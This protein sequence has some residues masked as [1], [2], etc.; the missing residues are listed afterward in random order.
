[1]RFIHW[2]W[3][4]LAFMVVAAC[5]VQQESGDD[6]V[7]TLQKEFGPPAPT[8]AVGEDEARWEFPD[9]VEFDLSGPADAP[10]GL[11]IEPVWKVIDQERPGEIVPPSDVPVLAI[12]QIRTISD[13]APLRIAVNDK[14]WPVS[15]WEVVGHSINGQPI[16]IRR[17]GTSGNV[18]LIIGG[19]DGSDRVAVKWLDYLSLELKKAPETAEDRQVILMRDPNPDGLQAKLAYNSRGVLINRNFPTTGYRP[20]QDQGAGPASEPETRAILEVLYRY[21]PSRV[22]HVQSAG[23]SE[24]IAN[25]SA[26]PLAEQLRNGRALATPRGDAQPEPGSLEEFVTQNFRIEMLTL[27]LSTGDD[28]QAAGLTHCPTLL[29][30]AIP[31]VAE[32]SLA[33]A[34]KTSRIK[35]ESPAD[36]LAPSPFSEAGALQRLNRSGYEE[37]PPPPNKPTW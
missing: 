14:R 17:Y 2:L 12:S 31:K 8:A 6:V 24:V 34:Q 26:E 28:W 19:L 13:E 29:A 30:A 3:P 22:I 37:L 1:M 7:A 18:T 32:E 15:S 36:D 11:V 23:R 16:H 5:I 4:L 9:S 25:A 27:R 20:G 33:I 35:P 10:A 21:R